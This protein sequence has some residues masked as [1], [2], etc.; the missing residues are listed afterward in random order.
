MEQLCDH[1]AASLL[2]HGYGA[3][4]GIGACEQAVRWAEIVHQ[5]SPK[6]PQ[7]HGARSGDGPSG[8][9]LIE[10]TPC[11]LVALDALRRCW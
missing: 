3:L 1:F 9:R 11:S 5:S 8:T 6:V 10:D 4:L 7:Q 2:E